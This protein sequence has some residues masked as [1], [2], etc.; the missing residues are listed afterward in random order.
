M[1]CNG[2]SRVGAHVWARTRSK[3]REMVSD[4]FTS[5]LAAGLADDLTERFLRYVRIDTTARREHSGTPS[6][7]GQ[8]TLGAILRDELLQLGCTDAKQDGHGYVTATIP[9]STGLDDAPIVGLI[10]HVDTSPDA[11]GQG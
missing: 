5:E 7:D 9:A 3:L 2:P 6:S 10:A 4:R 1:V 8:L 11:P